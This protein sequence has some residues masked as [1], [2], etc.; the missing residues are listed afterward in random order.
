MTITLADGRYLS[1]PKV[2]L[3]IHDA[4]KSYI[5]VQPEPLLLLSNGD[6]NVSTESI[7][8]DV[9]NLPGKDCLFCSRLCAHTKNIE[10][11]PEKIDTVLK[12][13]GMQTKYSSVF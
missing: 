2:L 7:L 10:H 8:K 5:R 13:R 3:N 6:G 9:S 11:I 12:V 1:D 4:C